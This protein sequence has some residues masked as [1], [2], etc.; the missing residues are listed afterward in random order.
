MDK[1]TLAPSGSYPGLPGGNIGMDDGMGAPGAPGSPPEGMPGE[2]G[3]PPDL[4]NI[5]VEWGY[6]KAAEAAAAGNAEAGDMIS[7]GIDM[8]LQGIQAI[9]GG[10]LPGGPPGLPPASTSPGAM[11]GM[12]GPSSQVPTSGGQIP[13]GSGGGIPMQY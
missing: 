11:K 1:T 2:E 13:F 8:V 5:F 7:N 4:A 6:G 9:G 10:E 12:G 3:A